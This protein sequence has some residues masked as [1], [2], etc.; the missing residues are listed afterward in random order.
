MLLGVRGSPP[1]H[2]ILPEPHHPMPCNRQVLCLIFCSHPKHKWNN[3][4]RHYL[5]ASCRLESPRRQTEQ[6]V[7]LFNPF[8]GH[9]VNFPM[10]RLHLL[11][12]GKPQTKHHPNKIAFLLNYSSCFSDSRVMQ[13]ELTSVRIGRFISYVFLLILRNTIPQHMEAMPVWML[14]APY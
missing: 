2:L 9:S 4:G 8:L 12:H 10:F 3:Y 6:V 11:L 14:L 5:V 13:A 1:H 7:Y